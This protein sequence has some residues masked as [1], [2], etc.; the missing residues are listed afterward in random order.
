MQLLHY[1]ELEHSEIREKSILQNLTKAFSVKKISDIYVCST[2]YVHVII[3][4][5]NLL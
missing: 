2:Y 5:K 3:Y 1:I 4:R